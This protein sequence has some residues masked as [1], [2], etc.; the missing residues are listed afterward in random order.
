MSTRRLK[1]PAIPFTFLQQTIDCIHQLW[2]VG[3]LNLRS[4]APGSFERPAAGS[5]HED[6]LLEFRRMLHAAVLQPPR[7]PPTHCWGSRLGLHIAQIATSVVVTLHP[8]PPECP[9]AH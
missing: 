6:L 8:A 7:A 2:L 3:D 4:V 9:S 1:T 5:P